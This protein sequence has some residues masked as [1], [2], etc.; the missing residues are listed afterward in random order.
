LSPTVLDNGLYGFS[1]YWFSTRDVL[2]LDPTKFT[3]EA[4]VAASMAT[5]D[6][7]HTNMDDALKKLDM[8]LFPPSASEKRV[9]EQ[10]FKAAWLDALL[11]EGHGVPRASKQGVVTPVSSMEGAEVQWSLGALIVLTTK[12]IKSDTGLCRAMAR[13]DVLDN[14]YAIAKNTYLR[15]EEVRVLAL[16][17]WGR[18]AGWSPVYPMVVGLVA[19]LVVLVAV[20]VCFAVNKRDF[21]DVLVYES[22]Y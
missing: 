2:Q 1:E 4:L 12:R 19:F 3:S 22:K 11:F 5:C 16:D 20:F 21:K 8:G 9:R 6:R 17:A 10:C 13:G 14:M 7:E 18:E 15:D